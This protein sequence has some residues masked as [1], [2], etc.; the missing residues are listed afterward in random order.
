MR[1]VNVALRLQIII[2][3]QG[4]GGDMLLGFRHI[5][6][7]AGRGAVAASDAAARIGKGTEC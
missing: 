7:E 1:N 6:R 3:T 4:P 5:W 2:A